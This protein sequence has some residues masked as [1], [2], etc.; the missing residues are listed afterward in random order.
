M[1]NLPT[2][3][4]LVLMATMPLLAV[5][6]NKPSKPMLHSQGVG[7][8]QEDNDKSKINL[9]VLDSQPNVLHG[10]DGLHQG[11]VPL[12]AISPNTLKT[13]VSV[14][15]LIRREYSDDK[16]DDELFYYA[17]NGMLT[18]VDS[19]AEFL[20]ADAF[21]NLQSFTTGKV[22]DIGI[23]ATWRE[24]I[25]YWVVTKAIPN[26]AA[27]MAGI[28][29]G[30]YIHQIGDVRLGVNQSQNDVAQLLNGI[31]GTKVDVVFSKAGRSKTT[32]TIE[33][34]HSTQSSIEVFV[35]DGIVIVKLPVFQTNTREQILNGISAVG[36]P[37]QGIIIDVRNNPGGVL[38]SAV[39]VASLFMRNQI[40]T[41][42]EGRGGIERVMHTTGSALL[43]E[44]P[45]II[46]QNRYSASAAEVLASGLQTQKRALVLGETSYGKGSV[47]SIIPIGDNQAVKLTTAH[48]LTATG[49]KIDKIGVKPDV[50][51]TKVD[52]QD[53]ATRDEWLE[54]ALAIMQKGKLATGVEFAPVG[55]F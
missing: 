31:Q 46:L 47:Q 26:S 52:Q 3:T 48:Y 15:D 23:T 14:V 39:D 41:Q 55:G 38:D 17:I 4:L 8:L 2:L 36:V 54:Q 45:V 28:D 53:D 40:V 34:T 9:E 5:A 30:D 43:D 20:N 29:V 18:K 32:K 19:H 42:V 27:V 44:I 37:V 22:A 21:A 6:Q 33:R 49:A 1:K 24:N 25:G 35:K 51:F 13:F 50:A 10:I 16:N 7:E 11:G 12:N